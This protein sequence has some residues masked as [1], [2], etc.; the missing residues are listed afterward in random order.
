MTLIA[1]IYPRIA[2]GDADDIIDSW[3]LVLLDLDYTTA[4]TAVVKM[5]RADEY[6]TPGRIIKAVRSIRNAGIPSAEEAWSEVI[7][8]LDP[9]KRTEW[10]H[11]V[12]SEAVKVMGYKSLLMS[13]NPS[14]DR[15]Q[16]L[17]IY[18]NLLE[19]KADRQ[20][21]EIICQITRQTVM[22]LVKGI[23]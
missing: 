16:F 11:E 18:N 15:A 7:K 13:E 3:N 22:K 20:E 21:N 4:K 5:L 2:E 1:S 19:R 6:P 12:I 14:I 17:K 23:G 10:S 8:K 9:Y